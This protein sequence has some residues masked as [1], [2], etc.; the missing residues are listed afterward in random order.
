MKLLVGLDL[1]EMD[2]HVIGFVSRLTSIF[3]VSKITFI[4]IIPDT[5]LPEPMEDLFPDLDEPLEKIV[6]QDLISS[7]KEEFTPEKA[8]DYD[9]LVLRGDREDEL[10]QA[11][12]KNTIDMLILGIKQRMGGTGMTI[13]RVVAYS[14]CST[15]YV[16]AKPKHTFKEVLAI[17]DFDK[18][19][20]DVLKNAIEITNISGGNISAL[21]MAGLPLHYFPGSPTEKLKAKLEKE[22]KKEFDKLLKKV[23]GQKITTF[24]ELLFEKNNDSGKVISRYIKTHK[25]DLL[26]I[27]LKEKS[28]KSVQYLH[29]IT[30]KM[31]VQGLDVPLWVVKEKKSGLKLI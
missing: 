1:G 6:E 19:S 18:L 24:C 25:I 4:H 12:R 9:V 30:E 10:I 27:E 21:H 16:P 2:S 13:D 14:K 5:D 23:D 8:V 7:L 31:R 26:T 17:V 20:L 29:S 28:D 11:V 15:I 3:S 22:C